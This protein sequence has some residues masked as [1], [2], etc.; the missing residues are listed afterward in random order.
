M[1]KLYFEREVVRLD[2]PLH[3]FYN[4]DD[5][6]A[7]VQAPTPLQAM[8]AWGKVIDMDIDELS[9]YYEGKK[10]L[11]ICDQDIDIP[12]DQVVRLDQL[13]YSIAELVDPRGVLVAYKGDFPP[14]LDRPSDPR[15]M[16]RDRGWSIYKA[17]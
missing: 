16:I 1:S 6:Y 3:E 12:T 9:I 11:V 10:Y 5:G 14:R 15:I 4:G 13:G 8:T 7:L 17:K 2:F